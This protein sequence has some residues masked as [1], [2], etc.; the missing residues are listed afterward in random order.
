MYMAWWGVNKVS[1]IYLMQISQVLVINDFIYL[2]GS[3]A[4]L[5]SLSLRILFQIYYFCSFTSTEISRILTTS[6]STTWYKLMFSF[7][8][9]FNLYRYYSL[10]WT[11]YYLLLILSRLQSI[12]IVL[13]TELN[14]AVS[15]LIITHMNQ[16]SFVFITI[17]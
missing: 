3:L 16:C 6:S 1:P 12:K 2:L 11:T 7:N 9:V 10:G 13:G 17:I 14:L 5:K 15:T 4:L 8:N